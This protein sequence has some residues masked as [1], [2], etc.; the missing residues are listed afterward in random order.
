VRVGSYGWRAFYTSAGAKA[1]TANLR[2]VRV[3]GQTAALR[4]HLAR[5]GIL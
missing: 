5:H 2:A 3:M 1:H 4:D